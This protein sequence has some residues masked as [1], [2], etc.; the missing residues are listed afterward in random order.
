[1]VWHMQTVEATD[2]PAH[3]QSLARPLLSAKP[4]EIVGHCNMCQQRSKAQM[5]QYSTERQSE[6]YNSR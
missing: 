2:Q 5:R 3:S 6:S 1:M 4:D